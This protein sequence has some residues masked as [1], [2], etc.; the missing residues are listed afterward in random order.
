MAI[1]AKDLTQKD[2]LISKLY[3][4]KAG[5][6]LI[7]E[8]SKKIRQSEGYVKLA[9]MD[10]S[11]A[12]KSIVWNRDGLKKAIEYKEGLE[13]E[14]KKKKEEKELFIREKRPTK[15]LCKEE[16]KK[17]RV[18]GLRYFLGM[19]PLVCL[20]GS[21]TS[22]A[23]F[24]EFTELGHKL[25]YTGTFTKALGY[26]AIIYLLVSTIIYPIG[27]I[28]AITK[29]KGIRKESID[30]VEYAY[31][32]TCN[33][34]EKEIKDLMSFISEWDEDI[35]KYKKELDEASQKLIKSKQDL[36]MYTKKRNEVV[37]PNSTRMA[38]SIKKAL[39]MQF[40]NILVEKD[41]ENADL[42]IF[43]LQTG[44]ADSLKEA[45]L[46][47]D[48]QRQADQ[49]TAAICNAAEYLAREIRAVVG[50]LEG[51]ITRCCS[52]LSNQINQNHN[53]LMSMMSEVVNTTNMSADQIRQAVIDSS[54]KQSDELIRE[55]RYNQKFWSKP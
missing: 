4:L 16:Y 18:G 13:L 33:E 51:T 45:L 35:Q 43:Y 26:V 32:K 39:D 49:I 41:W 11:S 52:D 2:E 40:E 8:E 5:L 50:H 15:E 17:R 46:L 21:C 34:Y 54:Q 30:C 36:E 44:R 19:L 55:L 22:C 3:T 31:N 1:N 53:E 29:N 7:E 28:W 27:C 38:K 24:G 6:A 20:I 23:L 47:V 25:I 48:Q 42:I 14:L 37:I 10:I 9:N 12:E